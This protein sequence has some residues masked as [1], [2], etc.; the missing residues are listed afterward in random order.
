MVSMIMFTIIG[1][2]INAPF[3]YWICFGIYAACK[4]I[5][6]FYKIWED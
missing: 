1:F 4:V 3:F 6:I 5:K 2:I